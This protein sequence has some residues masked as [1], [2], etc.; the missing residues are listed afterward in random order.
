[1]CIL[2]FACKNDNKSASFYYWKTNFRLS[3]QE[4][5]VLKDVNTKDLYIRFFDVDKKNDA[6]VPLGTIN[7]LEDV[8]D[9]INIVPTVFITNRTFVDISKEEIGRLAKNVSSKIN[10]L[11][12]NANIIF[13]EFQI[14]CDWSEKTKKTYFEFLSNIQQEMPGKTVSVTIRLHQVKY[15]LRSGIPPVKN[16]VLMFYNMG[17]LNNTEEKNSI[18]NTA[19]AEKYVSY[20]KK[21]PLRLDYALPVFSWQLHKR[22]NKLL[23]LVSK[24]ELPDTNNAELLLKQ[25]PG[26]FK[27]KSPFLHKGR[28][29]MENDELQT[30][31]IGETELTNAAQLLAGSID[32]TKYHKI[33]FFDLDSSNF[34]HINHET[35][36]KILDV[37]N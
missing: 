12:A 31:Y 15:P 3:A 11:A 32:K 28:Y 6:I 25:K 13:N 35:I 30:E 21:Y 18:Y 33:I 23:G 37:L 17:K 7:N 24:N 20:I 27:I 1:M 29:Y 19:D 5:Q 8:P 36:K 2:L 14:D 4:K 10:V 16:G 9:S 34:K 26:V 22:N